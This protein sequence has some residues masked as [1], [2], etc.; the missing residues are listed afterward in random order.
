MILCHFK[1]PI[2]FLKG[3]PSFKRRQRSGYR[4][5]ECLL[6]QGHTHRQS[7]ANISNLTDKRDLLHASSD[8]FLSWK[9]STTSI[10]YEN[11]R[12]KPG[13]DEIV[14]SYVTRFTLI[15]YRLRI[16]IFSLDFC[17]PF[18]HNT[19][20]RGTLLASKDRS[21]SLLSTFQSQKR[22]CQN[23]LSGKTR[24]KRMQTSVYKGSPRVM[25]RLRVY[26]AK[27]QYYF[28]YSYYQQCSPAK[29][30]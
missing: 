4:R 20:S 19:A 28:A 12:Y 18:F 5:G 26:V 13:S 16:S 17:R 21:S 25:Q 2:V 7:V 9:V 8:A 10:F 24:P 6:W 14:Y 30:Q 29:M 15:Q 1:R 22:L 11:D 23:K 27:Q 3:L